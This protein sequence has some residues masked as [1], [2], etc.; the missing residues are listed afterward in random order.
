MRDRD[1][2]RLLVLVIFIVVA[3]WLGLEIGSGSL[4]WAWV[5]G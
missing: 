1:V 4:E 5:L 3:V 2:N